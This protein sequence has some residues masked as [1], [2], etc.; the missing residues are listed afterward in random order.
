MQNIRELYHSPNGDRWHLARDPDTGRV[1]VKHQAN[2]RSGGHM[3]EIEIGV[4]LKATVRS[5]KSYCGSSVHCWK[6][7]RPGEK[8]FNRRGG[9]DSDRQLLRT[10][11]YSR[12][13]GRIQREW[14]RVFP[15]ASGNPS[16]RA[17]PRSGSGRDDGVRQEKTAL[18]RR[19]LLVRGTS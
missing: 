13:Q 12:R 5:I 8:R 19:W 17:R 1:F 16:P 18:I 3:A 7:R 2:L 9:G 14:V 4:F 11:D 6:E 15:L 10:A